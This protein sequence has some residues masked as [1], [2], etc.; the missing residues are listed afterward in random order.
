[1]RT[2]AGVKSIVMGGRP[3]PGQIKGVGGIKGAETLGWPDIYSIAQEARKTANE[4][5]V[6]IL[7]R[8]SPIPSRRTSTAALNVRDNILPD[9]V[10]DGLPAQFV[11]EESDCRLYYTTPMVTDVTAMWKAAADVAFKG[12]ACA[13]GSLP[14]RDVEADLRDRSESQE[15]REWRAANLRRSVSTKNAA[16]KKTHRGFKAIP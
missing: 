8:L 1:M 9:N 16:F 15:S 5:Q 11:V 13:A 7:D 4:A 12:K 6:A 14:K 10:N 3:K 2:Q